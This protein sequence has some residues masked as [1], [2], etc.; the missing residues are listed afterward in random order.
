LFRQQSFVYGPGAKCPRGNTRAGVVGYL[1]EAAYQAIAPLRQ[2]RANIGSCEVSGIVEGGHGNFARKPKRWLEHEFGHAAETREAS[3]QF[4]PREQ[5]PRIFRKTFCNA[6]GRLWGRASRRERVLSPYLQRKPRRNGAEVNGVFTRRSM[7]LPGA[8]DARNAH[9]LNKF[10]SD[11][12][13]LR[14]ISVSQPCLD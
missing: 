3:S 4:Q 5:S 12:I 6:T 11:L 2:A 14:Q 1:L 9:T 10:H 7:W 13:S 8:E